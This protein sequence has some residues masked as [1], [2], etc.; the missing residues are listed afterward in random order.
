M[1]IS[2]CIWFYDVSLWKQKRTQINLYSNN[3]RF[4]HLDSNGPPLST[5]Q[6]RSITILREIPFVVPFNTR[7]GI[8]QGLLAAD[9]LRFV[10]EIQ[11]NPKHIYFTKLKTFFFL[12]ISAQGDQQGFLQGPSIQLVVRRSHLYEDA[13]DKLRPENGEFSYF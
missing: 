12:C 13:F 10:F 6:I 11:K 5:K 3:N 4:D 1:K 9:R 2:V 7:V 8:F